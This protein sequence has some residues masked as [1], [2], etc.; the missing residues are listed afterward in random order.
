MFQ[1]K[2][3]L[4]YQSPLRRTRPV[5][6]WQPQSIPQT[7][8][9]QAGPAQADSAALGESSSERE[10]VYME[11]SGASKVSSPVLFL[12]KSSKTPMPLPVKLENFQYL[13][14]E[15]F[16]SMSIFIDLHPETQIPSFSAN[17]TNSVCICFQYS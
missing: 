4:L 1:S 16:V 12:K 14:C 7:G 13:M 8:P 3:C 11:G 9:A 10:I 17:S 15:F 2:G 6:T 5:S